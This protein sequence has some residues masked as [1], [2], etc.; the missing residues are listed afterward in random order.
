VTSGMNWLAIK[1]KPMGVYEARNAGVTP[2]PFLRPSRRL[3]TRP[4]NVPIVDL[5]PARF[6]WTGRALCIALRL[7][8]SLRF[9]PLQLSLGHH[10]PVSVLRNKTT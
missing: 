4:S 3:P 8:S 6:A 7:F 10:L 2:P 9:S 1:S 5:A